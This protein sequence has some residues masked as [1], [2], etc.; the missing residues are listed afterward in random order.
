M[1]KAFLLIIAFFITIFVSLSQN[2][3]VFDVD[4][5]SFPTMKAKF[6]AYDNN[7]Q[8][9]LNLGISD[10]TVTESGQSRTVTYV[11]CPTVNPVPISS[12][13]TLDISGSM[14]WA[15]NYNINLCKEAAKAWVKAMNL[16]NSECAITSF[17]HYSYFNQDF[18]QNRDRLLEK[19]DAL[20]GDG[21]TNYDDALYTPPA[22]GVQVA[23]NG[24]FKRIIIFLSDGQPNFPPNENQIISTAQQ[25]NIKIYC[26]ILN[27]P[28]PDCARRFA[29]QTGGECY[30][31][32]KTEQEAK[33]IF[34]KILNQEMG[35]GPCEI[36][37][38]SEPEC[39]PD[40]TTTISIP[41]KSLSAN[42]SYTVT[43][44]NAVPRL[45]VVP[46]AVRLGT[47]APGSSKDTTF[48][49]TAKN[50]S[51]SI[52]GITS[53]NSYFTIV[54]AS[55]PVNI[56]KDESRTF[57]VRFTP[58]DSG[59]TSATFTIQKS[60]CGKEI[61]SIAG[62]DPTKRT[63]KNTLKLTHPN[64]GEKFLICSDTI[65]TWEGVLPTDTVSLLISLDSGANWWRITDKALNL[66]YRLTNIPPV[67]SDKCLVKVILSKFTGINDDWIKAPYSG[68]NT[69]GLSI[70]ADPDTNLFVTG[71]F[72]YEALMCNNYLR[73]DAMSQDGFLMKYSSNHN[74][75][76][77]VKVGGVGTDA[78]NSVAIDEFGSSY[79]TGYFQD[80]AYFG[81]DKYVK[82]N[83][84]KRDIFIAKF[85]QNGVCQWVVRAGSTDSTKDDEGNG[86]A[87]DNSGNIYITGFFQGTADFGNGRQVTSAGGKDI[88]IAKYNSSGVCQWVYRAGSNDEDVANSLALDYEDNILV[89]GWFNGTANFGNNKTA[90]SSGSSDIFIAKYNNSG[91]CQWVS[92]AGSA[93]ADESHKIALDVMGSAFITGFFQSTATFR[94]GLSLT[95]SGSKDMFIAKYNKDG[96][97][98]WA[99]NGGGANADEGYGLI[100]DYI[101]NAFVS[102]YFQGTATFCGTLQTTAF[103]EKDAF[104]IKYD[105]DGECEWLYHYG[106]EAEDI[107]Y[108]ISTDNKGNVYTTGSSAN[109][110]YIFKVDYG[111]VLQKDISDNVFSLVAPNIEAKNVNFG[112]GLVNYVFDSVVVDCIA[113]NGDVPV[114]IDSIVITGTNAN[115]FRLI[116]GVPPYILAPGQKKN[117]EFSFRPSTIGQK[118]A[119]YRVYMDCVFL[120]KTLQGEA[121]NPKLQVVSKIIDFGKVLVSK[122]KDTIESAIKNIGSTSITIS[123]TNLLGPDNQQFSIVSGGGQFALNPNDSR[124]MTFK[125]APSEVGRTSTRVGFYY[126]GPGSPMQLILYGEGIIVAEI[127]ILTTS[128]DF[129]HFVCETQPFD[130]LITIRN[131]GNDTLIIT[132]ARFVGTSASSF[133]F[134][135][136]FNPINI[137]PNETYDLGIRFNPT[138]AGNKTANLEL[139]T[140]AVNSQNGKTNINLTGQKDII[141]FNIS[142]NN[143]NFS[144]LEENTP[145]SDTILIRNTGTLPI[146]WIAPIDLGKFIIESITPSIT[147]PQSSSIV[148]IKFKGG[149]A[150]ISYDTSYTFKDSCNNIKVL[151]MSANVKTEKPQINVQKTLGFPDLLCEDSETLDLPIVNSGGAD[152]NVTNA[153]FSGPD[154]S[155]FAFVTPFSPFTLTPNQTYTL[156]L[157][158]QPQGVG[159]KSA[160]LTLTSNAVNSDN[161][162]TYIDLSGI[163]NKFEFEFSPQTVNFGNVK[164]G[165]KKTESVTITNLGT[166][167]ILWDLLFPLPMFEFVLESIVPT[168]TPPNGGQSVATISITGIEEN[169]DIERNFDYVDTCQNQYR[170]ILKAKIISDISE[171]IY[172]G[173]FLLQNVPNPAYE[174]TEVKY[175]IPETGFAELSVYDVLGVK[176]IELFNNVHEAGFYKL[177]IDVSVLPQGSYIYI[178]KIKDKVFV[179]KLEV[180]R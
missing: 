41:A 51:V 160:K 66:K 108:A 153:E 54:G 106:T 72:T 84:S 68:M 75:L 13:L 111:Q 67:T 138:S 91:T 29:S 147:Q 12:V 50:T 149:T 124:S 58:V 156:N 44:N 23:K 69:V 28:A 4:A 53:N 10:F 73:A 104:M 48:R 90:T 141:S 30:D 102:G 166:M 136:P 11:S 112:Q 145:V 70:V 61:F 80:S 60:A 43:T 88:F 116:S 100:T 155:S 94:T 123:N 38:T 150:G 36:R 127:E 96:L 168:T 180:V 97:C 165:E 131:T 62:G 172:N 99:N 128:I 93:N 126:S 157:K 46:D 125:F 159:A 87:L 71:R 133:E 31:W 105:S 24:R 122:S 86:I 118:T 119:N 42:I 161:G 110:V 173:A 89:T 167:P 177:N 113:N 115:D 174:W 158:F 64:G 6:I 79:I 27:M 162:K 16:N 140:N 20:T 65:I 109:D 34:L 49:V 63:Q 47:I 164:L 176:R 26:V 56:P 103:G 151:N 144:N 45:E 18:T 85:N 82:S 120:E 9:L 5:S 179:R 81:N 117:L 3:S 137:L 134:T 143:I 171:F 57:T 39:S 8:R 121:V 163:K 22:G 15:P 83:G 21:G 154:A 98:I 19:I 35:I 33:D 101:G 37:W 25:N 146:S 148:T 76:W 130:T 2:L 139:T 152:L 95:S 40:K 170:L 78:S 169:S 7:F 114:P 77:A 1:R 129:P 32:V 55:F 92:S 74:C 14:T 107:D 175:Y 52:T 59:Y 132:Q 178:L 142:R 135:Q 17:N